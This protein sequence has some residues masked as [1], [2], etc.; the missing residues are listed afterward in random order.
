M[1]FSFGK[2]RERHRK[3][4]RKMKG[5]QMEQDYKNYEETDSDLYDDETRPKI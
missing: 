2:L 3:L 4:T 1:A 5:S